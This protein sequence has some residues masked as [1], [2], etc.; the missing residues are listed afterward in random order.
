[1][2]KKITLRERITIFI[3]KENFHQTINY[4]FNLPRVYI[5]FYFFKSEKCL[6][7]LYRYVNCFPYSF[8]NVKRFFL[9]S[10]FSVYRIDITP[11]S[12]SSRF[13]I[14]A[15]AAIECLTYGNIAVGRQINGT[16]GVANLTGSSKHLIGNGTGDAYHNLKV[17]GRDYPQTTSPVNYRIYARGHGGSTIKINNAGNWNSSRNGITLRVTEYSSDVAD[18]TFQGTGDTL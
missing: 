8:N 10:N 17:T 18:W 2:L 16:G 1:M 13:I 4:L 9:N 5:L 3:S 6:Y 12:T 7:I 11:K 15:T 14:E